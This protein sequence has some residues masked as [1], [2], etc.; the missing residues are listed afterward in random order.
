MEPHDVSPNCTY[1]EKPFNGNI[2]V[3]FHKERKV[4]A[5]K[6]MLIT[7]NMIEC[8]LIAKHVPIRYIHGSRFT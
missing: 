8:G 4:D 7:R 1:F 3:Y 2:I 5:T 6:H